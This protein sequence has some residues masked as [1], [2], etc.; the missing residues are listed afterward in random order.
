MGSGGERGTLF[1]IMVFTDLY[2]KRVVLC[3][4]RTDRRPSNAEM[5]EITTI[6]KKMIDSCL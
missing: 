5:K 1:E 4:Y 6:G 2:E 3:F